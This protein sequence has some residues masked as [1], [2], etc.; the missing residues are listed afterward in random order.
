[1]G[2]H[3]IYGKGNGTYPP[4]M[5]DTS[6][7]VPMLFSHPSRVPEGK[8]ISS[9][10]SHYDIM[11]TLLDYLNIENPDADSLPGRS[12]SALLE[13]R[14]LSGDDQVVVFDEYGPTRMIRTAEWKY[15]HRYPYGP[16]ELYD[17]V[18]D[19]DERQNLDRRTKPS[20]HSGIATGRSGCVVCALCRSRARW[21]TRSRDGQR[22]VGHC[23]TCCKGAKAIWR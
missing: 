22:A 15:I 20:T 19:P 5:F 16:H 7:K 11:S 2:H 3:G 8:V 17:L 23:W 6:V 21:L 12:F 9:L 13:G 10:H 18:N 14:D 4:N 1:M